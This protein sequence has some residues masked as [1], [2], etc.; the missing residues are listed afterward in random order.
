MT[1][2]V[3]GAELLRDLER[4]PDR[5][6]A[7]A[8]DEQAL[9]AREPARGQERL[10]VGDRDHT[11]DDRRVEGLGPEVLADALDQV[12]VLARPARDVDRALGVGADDR[13]ASGFCSFR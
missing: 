1:T 2:V 8:A 10:A 12:R 13:A 7:G 6:A 9:L 5:G 4:R 11:V 3:A